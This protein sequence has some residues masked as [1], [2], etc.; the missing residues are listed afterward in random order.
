MQEEI[1]ARHIGPVGLPGPTRQL[2]DSRELNNTDPVVWY[3]GGGSLLSASLTCVLSS[4]RTHRCGLIPWLASNGL[5][6]I[7]SRRWNAAMNERV[8]AD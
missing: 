1:L 7:C 8:R 3:Y 4:H 2:P 5:D 6:D